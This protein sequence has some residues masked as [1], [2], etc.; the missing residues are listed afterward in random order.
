MKLVKE[1]N[2]HEIHMKVV[3]MWFAFAFYW[4][5][6]WSHEPHVNQQIFQTNNIWECHN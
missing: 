4:I 5:N 1:L 6:F 3:Q 2:K